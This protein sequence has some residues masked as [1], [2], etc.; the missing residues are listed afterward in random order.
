MQTPALRSPRW[1][2]EEPELDSGSWALVSACSHRISFS[3]SE[4]AG[5]Q[6]DAM[7]RPW[8]LCVWSSELDSALLLATLWKNLNLS[9]LHGL[10]LQKQGPV[11]QDKSI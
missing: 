4:Y 11:Q 3:A 1:Q 8:F 10:L 6:P 9:E 7:E 2:R 5:Q